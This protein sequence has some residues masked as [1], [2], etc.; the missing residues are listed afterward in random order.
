MSTQSNF[1]V[2]CP[3]SV[4]RDLDILEYPEDCYRCDDAHII[5]TSFGYAHVK[6]DYLDVC[7]HVG[8]EPYDIAHQMVVYPPKLGYELH[9]LTD[10]L[11][12]AVKVIHK[13]YFLSYYVWMRVSY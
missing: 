4:A 5:T 3:Y 13:L 7:F 8:L 10:E 12:A 6:Q 9:K 11:I 1:I 2:T